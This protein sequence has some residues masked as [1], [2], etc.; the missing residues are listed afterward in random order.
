[1]STPT[2]KT[3]ANLQPDTSLEQRLRNEH[4]DRLE[5]AR[6]WLRIARGEEPNRDLFK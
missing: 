1:M 3:P 5:R 2:D 6:E 4:A